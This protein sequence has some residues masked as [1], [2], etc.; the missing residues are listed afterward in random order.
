MKK[1]ILLCAI[2]ITGCAGCNR[3]PHDAVSDIVTAKD[4]PGRN[5]VDGCKPF[6]DELTKRLRANGVKTC[7]IYF[8]YMGTGVVNAHA[9]VA[10]YHAGSWWL[11]DNTF[12]YP[13]KA[14]GSTPAQFVDQECATQE[15][16]DKSFGTVIEYLSIK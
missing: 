2:V 15:A 12:P 4:I 6:A 1:L 10:Y 13:T 3:Y 16:A 9:I 5:V 8:R 14:D 7:E 11:A